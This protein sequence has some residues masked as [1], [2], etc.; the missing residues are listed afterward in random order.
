M[1]TI[2]TLQI[3]RDTGFTEGCITAPSKTSSLGT[4]TF[5]FTGLNVSRE[6]LFSEIQVRAPYE[7]LYDCS[8]LKAVYD[9]KNGTDVTVYGWVDDIVC[10]SD[11]QGSPMTRIIWHVD[12]W[13]TY[14]SNTVFGS[15]VVKRRPLLTTDTIPPQHYPYRFRTYTAKYDVMIPEKD[16][17]VVFSFNVR[18]F[19]NFE[20]TQVTKD[21]SGNITST[22]TVN[23]K[24]QVVT[25]TMW[26]CY[27]VNASNPGYSYTVASGKGTAP[28]LNETLAGAFDEKLGL[29]PDAIN[30]VFLTPVFPRTFTDAANLDMIGWNVNAGI[31]NGRCLVASGASAFGIGYSRSLTDTR[32]GQYVLDGPVCSDDTTTYAL[33]DMQGNIVGTIPWGLKFSWIKFWLVASTETC[34][35][36][37][38][39]LESEDDSLLQA[40]SEGRVF[41]TSCTPVGITSNATSS[42]VYSGAR[43]V[44]QEQRRLNTEMQKEK[45]MAGT[46]TS[47]IEGAT[48]GAIM[49]SAGGPIGMAVGALVGAVSSAAGNAMSTASTYNIEKKYNDKFNAL[50]D[51]AHANQTSVNLMP[52]GTFDILSNGIGGYWLVKLDNDEYSTQQRKQDIELN[53]L[54]VSEPLATCQALIDK[55]GPLQIENLVVRGSIPV[56]A[57]EYFRNRF[58]GGVRII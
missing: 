16:W 14:L 35:L 20:E 29:D 9:F 58:S 5:T 19:E 4:P 25:R 27:A 13:R 39:F 33:T 37:F 7:D 54:N 24:T 34:Y 38:A 48:S 10:S 22:T 57:K 41:T 56:Q 51:Y 23:G 53:G 21:N 17:C 28:S 2:T 12:Y 1:S 18:S 36:R 42:Y 30:S 45:G 55:G 49:G 44:E 6:R 3:W 11:T 8:Y 46:A 15:G 31:C 43:S 50:S 47:A 52:S 32:T 26:G 40:T